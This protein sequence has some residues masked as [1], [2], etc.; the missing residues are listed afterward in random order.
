MLKQSHRGKSRSLLRAA[1][2]VNAN[3]NQFAAEWI[4]PFNQVVRS[5]LER[6]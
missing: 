2:E 6:A 5:I 1:A 4:T 3:P